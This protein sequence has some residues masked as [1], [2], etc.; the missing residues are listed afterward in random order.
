M[1]STGLHFASESTGDLAR[2]CCSGISLPQ[3]RSAPELAVFLH[4]RDGPWIGRVLVHGDGAR[5]H[6]VRLRKAL[7]KNRFAASASRRAP[8][9][10]SIV[11][12]RLS[13][14]R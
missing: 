10:K 8:D 7:R 1:L 11:W 2:R 3:P 12:P 5:V 13:T 9:R 14:A 6:R 4:L